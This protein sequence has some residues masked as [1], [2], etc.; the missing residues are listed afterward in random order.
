VKDDKLL[1]AR[2]KRFQTR[3]YSVKAGFVEPGDSL[4]DCIRHEIMKE[5]DIK[6]KGIKYFGS[7]S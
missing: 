6:V 1:L 2:T 4:E 7:Q 5:I 3:L